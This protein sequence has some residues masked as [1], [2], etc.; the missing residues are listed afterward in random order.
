MSNE[1]NDEHIEKAH[2]AIL[3]CL[4]NK[5]FREAEKEDTTTKL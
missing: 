5:V 4:G 3:L 2:S 1:E